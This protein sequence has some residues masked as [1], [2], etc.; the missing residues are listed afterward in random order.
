MPITLDPKTSAPQLASATLAG[1]KNILDGL[2]EEG[3]L[4][5]ILTDDN[6]VSQAQKGLETLSGEVR[7]INPKGVYVNIA[8]FWI[9]SFKD[10]NIAQKLFESQREVW[11]TIQEATKADLNQQKTL[12]TAAQTATKT[13]VTQMDTAMSAWGVL[14]SAVATA[15]EAKKA[16]AAKPAEAATTT[17]SEAVIRTALHRSKTLLEVGLISKKEYLQKLK[18]AKNLLEADAQQ[19]QPAA[20]TPTAAPAAAAPPAEGG[21]AAAAAPPAEGG[22]ATGT[23]PPAEGGAATGTAPPA[24]ATTPTA[25]TA[26]PAPGLQTFQL[27]LSALGNKD[28][29]MQKEF[30]P[31]V[32]L[33]QQGLGDYTKHIPIAENY[34]RLIKAKVKHRI[35]T[36]VQ[37]GD[38]REQLNEFVLALLASL[39]AAATAFIASK[40]SKWFKGGPAVLVAPTGTGIGNQQTFKK[41]QKSISDIFTMPS[42]Q[43]TPK[44]TVGKDVKPVDPTKIVVYIQGLTTSL[45]NYQNTYGEQVSVIQ[46]A[47]KDA[48]TVTTQLGY[49]EPNAAPIA[50]A[51]QKIPTAKIDVAPVLA[52]LKKLATYWTSV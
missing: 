19:Q 27:A 7:K 25:A 47:A 44:G 26:A 4:K 23:A 41:N 42:A 48:G 30:Y 13:L 20:T 14:N 32:T 52:E 34:K 49:T 5:G 46:D 35:L 10:K 22:A 15:E 50:E 45:T 8:T 37:Q 11:G 36:E 39:L 21:A 9:D 17:T 3:K 12:Y 28:G 38:N 33:L 29:F 2:A 43:Q 51:A 31:T 16:E 18:E 24:A 40:F 6:A 1:F